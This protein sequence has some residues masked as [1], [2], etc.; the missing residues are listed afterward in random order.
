MTRRLSVWTVVAV[1]LGM[2]AG[3]CDQPVEDEASD[4]APA[5]GKADD[6]EQLSCDELSE[7]RYE[8]AD[9]EH[10]RD[11]ADVIERYAQ[12]RLAQAECQLEDTFERRGIIDHQPL[13]DY[14]IRVSPGGCIDEEL[15]HDAWELE[16]AEFVDYMVTFLTDF[17]ER[18]DGQRTAM[19]DTVDVCHHDD[20]D[21][22]LN[23]DLGKRT[24]EYG[25]DY[26]NFG[27][28]FREPDN[29]QELEEWWKDGKHIESLADIS[30]WQFKTQ[31]A[32][33]KLW[34]LF[35]PIGLPRTALRVAIREANQAL[36]GDLGALSADGPADPQALR[37]LV[38]DHVPALSG[39]AETSDDVRSCALDFLAT[40]DVEQTTALA[41][42]WRA[43]IELAE[44]WNDVSS[45]V[46]AASRPSTVTERDIT[47]V[48]DCGALSM[49]NLKMID[50]DF[51]LFVGPGTR[52][53]DPFLTKTDVTNLD[54]Q[55]NAFVCIYLIDDIQVSVDATFAL[56][57]A[58]LS[59][60]LDALGVD[61]R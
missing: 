25:V 35:D 13:T 4:D 9:S 12:L 34:R 47:I 50:V 1:I 8:V 52:K 27:I 43:N 32:Y 5:G 39:D 61:C 57:R 60:A 21:S 58:G 42:A 30:W 45:A 48:Q 37:R 28:G 16:T 31:Q 17:H 2:G 51:S 54:V 49:G 10:G 18:M 33:A 22:N 53:Y 6:V 40:A 55:Q 59:D 20:Y 46:V 29:A 3:G 24:L 44:A 19:F 14:R 26:T 41:D 38:R 23:L 56:E 15:E 36:A 7:V 11:R